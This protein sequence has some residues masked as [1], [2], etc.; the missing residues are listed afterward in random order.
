MPHGYRLRQLPLVMVHWS[1][2][3]GTI[4][5]FACHMTFLT[6]QLCAC[7]KRGTAYLLRQS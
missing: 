5:V 1:T 3:L 2:V 4:T 7:T 6:A